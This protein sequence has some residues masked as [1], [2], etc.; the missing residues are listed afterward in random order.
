MTDFLKPDFERQLVE[1]K[2]GDGYWI[3][4]FNFSINISF[5]K[6]FDNSPNITI[7]AEYF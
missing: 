3:E 4:A 6:V 1:D 7:T 2:R 5:V